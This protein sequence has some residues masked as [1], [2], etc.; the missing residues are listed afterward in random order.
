MS[1]LAFFLS[2][3]D[4]HAQEPVCPELQVSQFEAF[5]EAVDEE[6]L[7]LEF[8][9]A[10]MLLDAAEPR[11]P[12]VVEI[13][14]TADIARYAIRRAY[15]LALEIDEIEAQRWASLAWALDPE[16]TWPTYIP[17]DHA[18]RTLLSEAEPVLPVPIEGHGFVIPFGGGVFLDGRFLPAPVA[19]PG[20]PHL[21]QVGDGEGQ[22]VFSAW[23]DGTSF[24]E[25]LLGPPIDPLP[26]L[27][28]WF[29]AEGKV[30]R[31]ARP[32]TDTRRHRMESAAGFAVAGGTLFASALVA[33][34]AY[35]DRPVDGLFYTVNGATIASGAA[36]AT[37]VVLLGAALFGK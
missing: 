36:G 27:P 8:R 28:P 9:R 2:M 18:A 15:S 30:K 25:N 35:Q 34:A 14:P 22:I 17:P 10:R 1:S 4:A 19:E 23:Q 20:L 26:T 16:V 33:Q 3:V 13:V 37:A 31:A 5:L 12:C 24:P 11:L 32:W 6:Y 29:N 21:V 7:N